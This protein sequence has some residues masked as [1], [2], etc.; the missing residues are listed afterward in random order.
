MKTLATNCM[1]TLE[2]RLGDLGIIWT[3]INAGSIVRRQEVY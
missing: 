2:K 1:R 3:W